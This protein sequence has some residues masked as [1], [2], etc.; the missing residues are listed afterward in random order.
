MRKA[1]FPAAALAGVVGLILAVNPASVAAAFAQFDTWTLL[2][3]VALML[4]FYAL[5]GLRWHLLLRAIGARA[6]LRDSQLLNLAGQAMTAVLPLGD[7]TRAL[8]AGRAFGVATGA[9]AA[10]VTVQELS[11][12][13]L[14][15]LAAVPA[16]GRLPYGAWW[17][18]MVVGGIASVVIVL[19]VTR[20]FRGVHRVVSVAPGLRRVAADVAALQRAASQLLRRPDVAA[21]ALIDLARVI[22]ATAAL[23]LVL[24]GLH[25]ATL[26]WWEVALVLAASFIGGALSLLPGGVGA[27]EATVVGVLIVLGVSPPTAA[28]AAILQRLTLTGVPAAGGALAYLATRTRTVR[29]PESA[30]GARRQAAAAGA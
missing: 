18:A 19:T 20:V 25:V 14:V 1:V 17:I 10:T 21:G 8:L 30:A 24:R 16:L 26:G 22:V 28:A 2:P 3:A 4:G 13:L 6:R 7:L 12:T 5:Q 29:R 27:N 11:F 9:A 15:V 23:L